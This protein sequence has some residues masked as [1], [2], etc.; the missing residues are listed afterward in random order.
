MSAP[1]AGGT[2][3]AGG[4]RWAAFSESGAR[5]RNEDRWGFRAGQGDLVVWALAD[6]MG[7]HDD[8]DVAAT[9]GIDSFLDA[10][11]TQDDPEAAVR[12]GIAAARAAIATLRGTDPGDNAPS[13]TLV[14][15]ALKGRVGVVCHAGDS[16]LLQFRDG[17]LVHRTRDHNV[18]ELK[19]AVSGIVAGSATDDPDASKLTRSLGDPLRDDAED[20]VSR[21]ELGSGDLLLLCSDG[22]SQHIPADDPGGWASAAKDELGLL[23]HAR[24]TTEDA[25]LPR[26][27]NYTAVA[28]HVGRVG[29]MRT[30]GLWRHWPLVAA[31]LA[32]ATVI[33]Y[34]LSAGGGNPGSPATRQSTAGSAVPN[35]APDAPTNDD[36]AIV[37]GGART[38]PAET[39]SLPTSG[40]GKNTAA[41]PQPT[42]SSV[43]APERAAPPI[44]KTTG[45]DASTPKPGP[46]VKTC[47]TELVPQEKCTTEQLKG[48]RCRRASIELEFEVPWPATEGIASL[49]HAEGACRTQVHEDA[50]GKFAQQCEG[51]LGEV[52]VSCRC[53]SDTESTSSQHCEARARASCLSSREVCEDF[54]E[55]RRRCRSFRVARQVCD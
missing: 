6:G 38:S 53:E 16:A 24:R 18:R 33:A 3:D 35:Q 55:P 39:S 27:D 9:V 44:S 37:A 15:F 20:T 31:S 30:V 23:E 34:G 49:D 29:G 14:G 1:P 50:T 13:S 10:A 48:T 26:Q 42:A 4:H 40:S 5:E 52:S 8:G 32:A 51:S 19:R 36:K 7:G 43:L 17:Q 2:V 47:R 21:L 46:A 41:T 45:T 25:R 22:V 28:I 11:A 12:R 54:F